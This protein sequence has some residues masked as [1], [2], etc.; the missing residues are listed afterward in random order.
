MIT[1]KN[2]SAAETFGSKLGSISNDGYPFASQRQDALKRIYRSPHI[3]PIE[4]DP[5]TVYVVRDSI[6][7]Y[8]TN[9]QCGSYFCRGSLVKVTGLSHDKATS[10]VHVEVAGMTAYVSQDASFGNTPAKMNLSG[11]RQFGL[12]DASRFDLVELDVALKALGV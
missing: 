12:A 6:T 2:T 7:V 3:S 10:M 9:L 8:D 4:A 5:E 1:A 11:K